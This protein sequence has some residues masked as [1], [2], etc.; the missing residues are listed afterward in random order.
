MF[1]R[2][3]Y[4]DCTRCKVRVAYV[5]FCAL[6]LLDRSVLCSV[7]RQRAA[8]LALPFSSRTL[9]LWKGRLP[10]LACVCQQRGI[11][12][13]RGSKPIATT[14]WKAGSTMLLVSALEQTQ[15]AGLMPRLTAIVSANS[16]R[17]RT[18]F[19]SSAFVTKWSEEY[20][21]PYI[22]CDTFS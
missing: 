10:S 20:I 22:Y 4:E 19:A 1:G 14:G 12:S 11:E 3:Q 9:S 7:I 17:Y 2:Y 21:Y 15:K 18:W 6:K 16:V 8:E 5:I 13:R